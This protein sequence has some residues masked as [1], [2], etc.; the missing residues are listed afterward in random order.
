MVPSSLPLPDVFTQMQAWNDEVACVIDEY[1]GFAGMLTLEDVAE[2]LVGEISDETDADEPESALG[3]GWW[4]VDAGLRID[5]LAQRTGL[6]LPEG[7][8]GTLA[9]LIQSR[10]GRLAVPGDRIRV[11]DVDIE[12]LSIDHHVPERIRLR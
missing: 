1:G 5:E 7:D 11:D 4:H 2:E 12:V 9:G 3:D 8:Y 10:L 6:T